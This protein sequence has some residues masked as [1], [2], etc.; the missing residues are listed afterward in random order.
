M[1]LDPIAAVNLFLS[2]AILFVG[3]WVYKKG[4]D[5]MPL[6]IGLAFSM[7]GI[8]HLMTLMGLADQLTLVLIFIRTL[9]YLIVLYALYSR[10]KR[11]AKPKK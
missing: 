7:F 10:M 11:Q 6:L 9:G 8:S 2:V 4:G 1:A 3:Y 5:D